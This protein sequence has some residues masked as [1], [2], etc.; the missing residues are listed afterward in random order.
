MQRGLSQNFDLG[1]SKFPRGWS[2]A[3]ISMFE[4]TYP[5]TAGH[6]PNIKK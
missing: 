4:W 6:L 2:R 3:E 1:L 5:G